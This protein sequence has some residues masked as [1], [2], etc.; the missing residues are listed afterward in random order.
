M[1]ITYTK[2]TIGDKVLV[3]IR[4][5]THKELVQN[6]YYFINYGNA[7]KIRRGADINATTGLTQLN[8]AFTEAYFS[9]DT[10]ELIK[11]FQAIELFRASA[12][13]DDKGEK[14]PKEIVK[15]TQA[16]GLQRFNEIPEGSVFLNQQEQQNYLTAE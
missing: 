1:A 8:I 11:T 2:Q 15:L 14:I 6:F 9:A 10:V 3:K 4:A 12:N 5:D 13:Y 16:I 7:V